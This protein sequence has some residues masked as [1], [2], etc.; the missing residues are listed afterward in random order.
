MAVLIVV[1]AAA[2]WAGDDVMASRYGNTI[3]ITS[4]SGSTSRIYYS[5]DHTF[6]A[7]NG[8][9]SIGGT[10]SIEGKNLCRK[11]SFTIPGRPNPECDPVTPHKLGE[12]W[13]DGENSYSLVKGIQ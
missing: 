3:V 8:F 7:T 12:T 5:A 10:W 1:T 9:I 2:A 4:A 13:A 6:K 11:Y